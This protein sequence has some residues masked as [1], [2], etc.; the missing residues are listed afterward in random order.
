MGR[1]HGAAREGQEQLVATSLA[2]GT[3]EAVRVQTALE[4]A[5]ELVLH[6]LRQTLARALVRVLEEALQVLL[7][8]AVGR[9]SRGGAARTSSLRLP[10]RRPVAAM[11]M[12]VRRSAESRGA[13]SFI[14]LA[15]ARSGA[16]LARVQ[17]GD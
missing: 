1:A 4:V 6:V 5:S 7:H 2:N 10:A 3:G 12:P 8:D 13:S 16:G 9:F 17:V 14:P 15:R 11:A